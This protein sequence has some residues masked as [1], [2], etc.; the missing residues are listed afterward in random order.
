MCHTLFTKHL[1]SPPP[2]APLAPVGACCTCALL[3]QRNRA[4]RTYACRF[5]IVEWFQH[6]SLPHHHSTIFNTLLEQNHMLKVAFNTTIGHGLRR[7][8]V[9]YI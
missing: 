2:A 6:L 9:N 1:L 4:T 5:N 8:D 7:I 3:A